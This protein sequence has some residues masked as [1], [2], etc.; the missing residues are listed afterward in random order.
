MRK[1]LV[2]CVC[3]W[4]VILPCST[5]LFLPDILF[6]TIDGINCLFVKILSLKFLILREGNYNTDKVASLGLSNRLE[7]V[8]YICMSSSISLDSFHNRYKLPMYRFT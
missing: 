2:T 4:R 3:G 6:P 8:W 5:L 7:Y 1:R